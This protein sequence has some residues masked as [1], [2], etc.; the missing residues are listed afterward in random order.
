MGGLGLGVLAV[1]ASPGLMHT[2]RPLPFGRGAKLALALAVTGLV[3]R[4]APDLGLA[5]LP[6]PAHGLASAVWAAAFLI[7][8]AAYWPAIADPATTGAR[9]C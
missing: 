3:L 9:T 5:D 2:G 4:I 1:S 6:G 7:W 8:F